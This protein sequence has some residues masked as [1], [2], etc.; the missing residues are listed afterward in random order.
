MGG[1]G[2]GRDGVWRSWVLRWGVGC[3]GR[4]VVGEVSQEDKFWYT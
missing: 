2:W 4:G 1:I 3:G